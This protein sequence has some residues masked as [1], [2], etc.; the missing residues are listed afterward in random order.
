MGIATG[1]GHI[2]DVPMVVAPFTG[3]GDNGKAEMDTAI[4]EY[5]HDDT[6]L[7][8]RKL[9]EL[10]FITIPAWVEDEV[11]VRRIVVAMIMM[12]CHR[13]RNSGMA[14]EGERKAMSKRCD[15]QSSPMGTHEAKKI[16]RSRQRR[17][18]T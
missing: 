17:H 16:R 15:C 14:E 1:K 12:D 7:K 4:N 18:E 5:D 6:E 9:K 11:G 10:Q 2:P 13:E 8:D 3:D